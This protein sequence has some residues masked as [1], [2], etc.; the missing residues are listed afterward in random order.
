MNDPTP[1]APLPEHY[2]ATLR[3]LIRYSCVMTVVGVL[4]GVLFQES[5]KKLSY[6]D[7]AA[8]LHL[9]AVYHLALVHGHVLFTA[10]VLPL[11]LGGAM[12]LARRIG[13]R[14]LRPSAM[15][16]L[17]WGYLPFT[18]MTVALMLYKG[19]HFLLHVRHGITDL[20]V[21][22][23]ALFGGITALR[24]VVY[25]VAHTGMGLSLL[26]FMYFL[27]RSLGKSAMSAE[28]TD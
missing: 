20:A 1:Q 23:E 11:L 8:G 27:W 24:Q 22:N 26:L 13:G 16:W 2:R 9:E 12:V 21:V 4:A 18:A 7:A 28:R 17:V 14:E 5:G 3:T 25:G 19:Y 15:R 6:E 10:V